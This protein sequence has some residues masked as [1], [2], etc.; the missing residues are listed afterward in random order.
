MK[1][2]LKVYWISQYLR[3]AGGEEEME[4]V[5]WDRLGRGIEWRHSLVDDIVR[6][7]RDDPNRV[8]SLVSMLSIRRQ[9]EDE[10]AIYHDEIDALV[11]LAVE[12]EITQEEF[13]DRLEAITIAVMIFAFFLGSVAEVDQLDETQRLL[14]DAALTVLMSKPGNPFEQSAAEMAQYNAGTAVLTNPFFLND[15]LT[16][17]QLELLQEEIDQAGKSAASFGD[18]ITVGKYDGDDG[19]RAAA[20]R[21]LSLI[22]I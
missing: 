2:K 8:M 13:E 14:Y 22:H 4:K 16:A 21:T 9:I 10:I 7:N 11:N 3:D 17:A 19:R 18:A 5:D 15:G 20:D 1:D 6:N 12:G